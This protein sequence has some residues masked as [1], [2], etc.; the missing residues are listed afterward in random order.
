MFFQ[1][2]LSTD[3]SF[4]LAY[5]QVRGQ[6]QIHF[7]FTAYWWCT[8]ACLHLQVLTAATFLPLRQVVQDL[9]LADDKII[10]KEWCLTNVVF[11]CVNVRAFT[12]GRRCVS[13]ICVSRFQCCEL[14][15]VTLFR[16]WGGCGTRNCGKN[17]KTNN[18]SKGCRGQEKSKWS[19]EKVLKRSKE[20]E[21]ER[22]D[23][24]H[25]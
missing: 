1:Q 23:R 20:R 18:G 15:G 21:T 17:R 25:T 3:S 5:Y 14:G 9:Q 16:G 7:T 8:S 4:I 22:L 11:V 12:Q 2:F 6:H 24:S 19:N 13:A 10:W